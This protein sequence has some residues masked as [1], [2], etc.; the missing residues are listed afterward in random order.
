MGIDFLDYTLRLE[1]QYRLRFLPLTDEVLKTYKAM[2]ETQRSRKI[3]GMQMERWDIRVG[4][5]FTFSRD[6]AIPF[7]GTCK[8]SLR[9]LLMDAGRCPKCGTEYRELQLTWEQFQK[10][11]AELLRKR[12]DEIR[13]DVW[14]IGDL[15]FS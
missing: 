3:L 5:F 1:K 10:V 14:L 4:N 8:C 12:P 2:G 11:L 6:H 7:C 15:K 9:N 13:E